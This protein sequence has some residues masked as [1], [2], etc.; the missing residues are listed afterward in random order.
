M[1]TLFAFVLLLG[2]LIFVHELGHFL[3][4]K[5]CGVRV[6]KFSLGFGSPVG[7]GRFRLAW[8]R[9]HTE[10][11][12]AW[13]P[14]GG[15]VKMLGENPDEIDGAEARAHPSETLGAKPVW[16]KLAVIFAGPAMNLLLPVFVFVGT[17]AVGLPRAAPVVGM[18]EAGSP[19]ALAG[20]Q[21]AD[22]IVAIGGAPV[23]WWGEIEDEIRAHP[24]ERLQLAVD[25][26]EARASLDLAVDT[27]SG[28]DEFG[29]VAPMGWAGIGHARRRAM[30]GIPDAESPAHRAGLLS[31]DVVTA[32]AGAAV[33]DWEEFAAAYAA[34]G[35][36]GEVAVEVERGRT[37]DAETIQLA[38]PAGG[39]IADLGV[40]PASVLVDTGGV[41]AGSPAEQSGLQP[42]DLILAAD[43]QPLGSFASFAEM[44]RTGG[45]APLRLVFA[46]EGEVHEATVTPELV[47]TDIG[48]GIEEPRYRIGI[49][50][51]EALTVGDL[52]LDRERNPLVSI[53]RAVSMTVDMTTTFL[54]GFAKLIT[55][56]VSSRSLAG[57][58]G[59]AEIAGAAFERGWET[60]LSIMVLI[61][62]NLGILNLL[63]IPILDGGQALLFLVEGVKRSPLSLRTREIVQQIGLIGSARVPDSSSRTPAAR[64][65][66][67]DAHHERRA[68]PRRRAARGGGRCGRADGGREPAARRRHR[69]PRGRRRRRATRRLRGLHRPR[70]VHRPARGARDG[71]GAGVRGRAAG[72]TGVH[73]RRPGLHGPAPGRARRPVARCAARR[74]VRGRVR[75]DG[76]RAAGDRGGG[77][78]HPRRAD[79]PVASALPAGGRR[80]RALR[81]GDLLRD[82]RGR[83]GRF[84][85]PGRA[86]RGGARRP[87]ARAR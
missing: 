72:G 36:Q 21:P 59:I 86:T 11:V 35:A 49:R 85:R 73:A 74:G 76:R 28:F 1:S 48:L 17:L 68:A 61:S 52:G 33:E 42:G 10:Y 51:A 57:P 43:G 18:V 80:R 69:A 8:K 3:V 20:L 14:L 67:R 6:L 58:I 66:D 62:I 27:R 84:D 50:G 54:R 46:R 7:F 60:Y 78:V 47:P 41:E 40:V 65:G 38:L 87:H 13:F 63:P 45:G 16:Q 4:A 79:R 56:E 2:I 64:V 30:V 55:G 75:P 44:V 53:P 71:E 12:V 31:G 83:P 81:R 19:A 24:G 39:A 37:E 82:R 70:I 22:R 29:A 25:R 32:V 23:Q 77:R 5:A 9:G 26:G 34:A 15:F